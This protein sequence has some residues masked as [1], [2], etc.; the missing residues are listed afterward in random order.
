MIACLAEPLT[1]TSL[2]ANYSL[3]NQD[4]LANIFAYAFE[5]HYCAQISFEQSEYASFLMKLIHET[6]TSPTIAI[7]DQNEKLSCPYH[8][9][10]TLTLKA[11]PYL[12]SKTKIAD[13]AKLLC[14]VATASFK[15]FQL[16]I[17]EEAV[18]YFG[19]SS[20]SLVV[21]TN[22]DI[23][24]RYS[25]IS[26]R[27]IKENIGNPK[28]MS[29]VVRFEDLNG[30][31]L[32]VSTFNCSIF[33]QIGPLDSNGHPKWIYGVEI[34]F[35]HLLSNRLN[36]TY[37]IVIP[38]DE[39]KRGFINEQGMWSG[40]LLKLVGEKQVDLAFCGILLT[41][42]LKMSSIEFAPPITKICHKFLVPR[43]VLLTN[44]VFG[45]FKPF[46]THLWAFITATTL[47]MALCFRWIADISREIPTIV[48]RQNSVYRKYPK[49]LFIVWAILFGNFPKSLVTKGPLRHIVTWWA[50]FCML[51]SACFA[52]SLISH[53]TTPTYSEKMD[54]LKEL[55]EQEYFWTT[56]TM[57][58]FRGIFN[59][60]DQWQREWIKKFFL[61]SADEENQLIKQKA[62]MAVFGGQLD[63]AFYVYDDICP[64]CL[65]AY[66]VS[67]QCISSHTTGFILPN[68]SPYK[69]IFTHFVRIFQERGL[70]IK[71]FRDISDK[72]ALKKQYIREVVVPKKRTIVWRQQL[73]LDNII[74]IFYAFALGILVSV[75][76]FLLE[77]TI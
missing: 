31:E 2:N 42:Y 62:K 61:S 52:S 15:D 72:E 36:F 44:Q 5:R 6:R 26:N 46:R 43:P 12:L 20:G 77:W 27:F 10:F 40:G 32:T 21:L 23:V 38:T 1:L 3:I 34:D 60:E 7:G 69:N 28:W 51:M 59:L 67:S 54:T 75:L 37:R 56:N 58:D 29:D 39:D 41:D 48:S 55:V 68:G 66:E 18:K 45:I 70:F 22:P 30:L 74:G 13:R 24:Y 16:F 9:I 19:Q 25:L 33:S 49:S 64:S 63:D 8:I 35:L 50:L 57:L 14:L 4:N 11:L 47:F 71:K 65:R 17:K 53:L 73:E 76:V